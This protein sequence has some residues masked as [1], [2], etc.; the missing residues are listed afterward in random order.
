MVG[1]PAVEVVEVSLLEADTHRLFEDVD[2]MVRP[3]SGSRFRV[4]RT[5]VTCSATDTSANTRKATFTVTVK[6]RR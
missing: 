2:D 4:G 3:R 5:R 1:H 6:P